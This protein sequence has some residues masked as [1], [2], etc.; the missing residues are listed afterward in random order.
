M[1]LI[2]RDLPPLSLYVYMFKLYRFKEQK[3]E[4][5]KCSRVK[6]NGERKE[7]ERLKKKK[8][9]VVAVSI[10]NCITF[11]YCVGLFPL[12]RSRNMH[13]EKEK[14][15][16]KDRDKKGIAWYA[17]AESYSTD[18]SIFTIKHYV[19]DHL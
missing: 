13:R 2:C 6:E 1:K 16:K 12:C 8:A 3:L 19:T 5:K 7:D 10:T 15:G 4:D 11:Y 9:F 18:E 14:K 17:H